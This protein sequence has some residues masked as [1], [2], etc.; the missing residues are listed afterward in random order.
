MQATLTWLDLTASDRDKMRR[1]LDL[2]KEQG[3]LDEMGL[4]SLR[5]VLSDTLFPG[6]S[7]IQTRLRYVLFIP[8]I[9]RRL[10]DRKV[11]A[12]EVARAARRAEVDLIGPLE[13]NPAR[14][15]IIGSRARNA[16]VRLPSSVYWS[17]LT[18][19]GIFQPQQSLGWYHSRFDALVDGRGGV[20]R[21]DDPGVIWSQ[22]AHWHPRLPEPPA[23][24]PWEASFA[25]THDEADFLRGRVEERLRRHLKPTNKSWRVDETYV[26]VKG[27]WCYLYRAIDST[28]ATIDFVLSGL[29]DA[30]AAKRLF[31]KALTDPSHP[32]P[33]VINTDQARLYGAAISGVKKEGILRRRCRHRPIQYLNNILEQDHRA[34]KRRVKAKQGF[35]EFHAARRTI[36]GYEAMHMIRKGQARRVNG[37][38]VRQQIQFI[39]KLFGVA[40]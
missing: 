24:F 35:R 39:N 17:A 23:G 33:R 5:D 16:L 18:R 25:L 1:V 14:E 4:G 2:F 27:R 15:G 32:Q 7:S 36:Q 9:Y 22:Q 8:W 37:S 28:G 29:R 21:A 3:T 13:Q 6:T 34:I 26:R 38:D 30:A 11:R 31:R 19:W 20:G 10:E 40:A 12:A